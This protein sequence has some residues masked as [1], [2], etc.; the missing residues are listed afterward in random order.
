M[1]KV[2]DPEGLEGVIA[3]L[4]EAVAL[5]AFTA[6]RPNQVDG[7][8]RA[9]TDLAAEPKYAAARRDMLRSIAMQLHDNRVRNAEWKDG[10][11]HPK[12]T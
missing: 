11:A 1:T 3:A 7:L 10:L 2:V 9:F 6:C 4:S 5:V 8:I 12:R